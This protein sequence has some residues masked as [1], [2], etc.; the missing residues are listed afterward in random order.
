MTKEEMLRTNLLVTFG[1][2]AG[3]MDAMGVIDLPYGSNG[4]DLLANFAD[5]VVSEYM[6]GDHELCYDEFIEDAL[7]KQYRKTEAAV[8]VERDY[9]GEYE[10]Y[11]LT[12]WEFENEFM[13]RLMGGMPAASTEPQTYTLRPMVHVWYQIVDVGG[14]AW[15]KFFTDMQWGLPLSDIERGHMA[16]I[17]EDSFISLYKY[18]PFLKK[19]EKK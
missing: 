11:A 6:A 4:E 5:K 15:D 1:C 7:M 10:R 16:Y 18:L 12:P 3:H 17:A 19:G 8:L 9:K 13:P 2:R 14:R